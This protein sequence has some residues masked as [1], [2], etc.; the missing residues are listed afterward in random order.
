[1]GPTGP[2]GPKGDTGE[3]GPTGPTG[4]TGPKGDTGDTGPRGNVGPT[5]P[6][7]DT[8]D[9]GAKGDTGPQGPAGPQGEAG[10]TGPTG[11]MGPKGDTGPAGPTGLPAGT[12]DGYYLF[13]DFFFL[14]NLGWEVT[15]SPTLETGEYNHPG[16]WRFKTLSGTSS[17]AAASSDTGIAFG[18]IVNARY[19]TQLF[20]DSSGENAEVRI[21]LIDKRVG[22]P[23]T[24]AWF[25][26][27]GSADSD[28]QCVVNGQIVHTF[29]GTGDLSDDWVWFNITNKGEGNCDFSLSSTKTN[30]AWTHSYVGGAIDEQSMLLYVLHVRTLDGTRKTVD[31]DFFDTRTQFPNR[32]A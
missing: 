1:M 30:L 18:N 11:P 7:G 2:A 13:D 17:I 27:D 28:W 20:T 9:T 4:P 10:P 31:F 15:G 6:K 22:T 3:A 8:G 24:G 25:F 26:Y 23:E 21:G 16:I 32:L 5:G 19:L 12:P 14:N 29:T